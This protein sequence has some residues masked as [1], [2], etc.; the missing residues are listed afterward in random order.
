MNKPKKQS[1]QEKSG[2]FSH[3][4]EIIPTVVPASLD[5]V[6]NARAKNHFASGL[7]IDAADGSFAPNTTWVPNPEEKIPDAGTSVYEAHLMVDNPLSTGLAFVR[8][9]VKRIIGHVEA[10]SNAES[11]REALHMWKKAGA[12]E[13]GLGVLLDTPLDSLEP[14]LEFCDVVLFMSIATI[15]VQGI[16]FDERGIGR[17]KEFHKKNPRITIAVDG[18]VSEKNIKKFARAGA[19]R[20]SVGSALVK[21]EDPV[22]M[23]NKLHHLVG[24]Q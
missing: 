15:G 13:A 6:V 21:S 18:G 22:G 12:S 2:L 20:F 3:G 24:T 16:P 23:Y 1:S 5:D 7:H 11:A 14:Y 9:G 10:F 4:V 8:A 19:T 17:V